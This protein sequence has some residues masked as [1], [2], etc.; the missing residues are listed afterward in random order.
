MSNLN[1]SFLNRNCGHL[2]RGAFLCLS[3]QTARGTVM[4]GSTCKWESLPPP[5]A[6]QPERVRLGRLI[7]FLSESKH[8]FGESGPD[9]VNTIM[10]TILQRVAFRTQT[11]PLRGSQPATF[12]ILDDCSWARLNQL[13]FIHKKKKRERGPREGMHRKQHRNDGTKR[14]LSHLDREKY[15]LTRMCLKQL[16]SSKEQRENEQTFVLNISHCFHFSH[17]L[18]LDWNLSLNEVFASYSQRCSL[19]MNIG[20][21][22]VAVKFA[23]LL[24][25]QF[26]FNRSTSV[27]LEVKWGFP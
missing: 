13:P 1:W 17:T 23:E 15:S 19:H 10:V 11:C 6:S 22:H 9:L 12:Y 8:R 7:L 2:S 5:A 25:M 4:H 26:R 16:L 18:N 20:P 3:K 21:V 27:G 14:F 24:K